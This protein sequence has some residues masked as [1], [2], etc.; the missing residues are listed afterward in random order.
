MFVFKLNR[1]SRFGSI[2]RGLETNSLPARDFYYSNCYQINGYVQT[3]KQNLIFAL[4]LLLL[5]TSSFLLLQAN[6][7]EEFNRILNS[8]CNNVSNE[9]Q[10]IN[11]KLLGEKFEG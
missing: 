5:N 8:F 4:K 11:H 9:H 6:D 10:Q 2:R 3:S 1:Q 7:K